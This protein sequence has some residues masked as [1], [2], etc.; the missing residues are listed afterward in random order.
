MNTLLLLRYYSAI[1][2]EVGEINL[3]TL[4]QTIK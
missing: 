3:Y 4:L 1:A 2:A